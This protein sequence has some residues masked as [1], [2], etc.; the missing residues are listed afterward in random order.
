MSSKLFLDTSLLQDDIMTYNN[1]RFYEIIDQL[2]GQD[3][4]DLI[5]LQAIPNIPSLLLVNDIFEV[6]KLDCDNVN[7]I[8]GRI[9]FKLCD[10]KLRWGERNI[11]R[12]RVINLNIWPKRPTEKDKSR[13]LKYKNQIAYIKKGLSQS[14]G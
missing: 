8:R 5:K 7:D 11:R 9:T 2:V 3:I 14:F 1:N 13:A 10:R 12:V 6:L 4:S